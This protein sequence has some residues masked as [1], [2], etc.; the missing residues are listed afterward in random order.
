MLYYMNVPS[1][2]QQDCNYCT[3]F[4]PMMLDTDDFVAETCTESD[5][6]VLEQ[7]GIPYIKDSVNEYLRRSNKPFAG[8]DLVFSISI[9][10][11]EYDIWYKGYYYRIEDLQ[12]V[13]NINDLRYTEVYDGQSGLVFCE[14]ASFVGIVGESLRVRIVDNIILDVYEGYAVLHNTFKPV[15]SHTVK[16]V[17]MSREAFLRR[18][19]L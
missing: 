4:T 19:I 2:V 7:K 8:D 12:E 1:I 15:E 3:K 11:S 17:E 5:L 14:S 10:D 6:S 13:I 9:V 18:L 16:G